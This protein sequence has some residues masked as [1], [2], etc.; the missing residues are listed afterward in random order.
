MG[1]ID[2]V[3]LAVSLAI[4]KYEANDVPLPLLF[5]EYKDRG[6][7]HPETIGSI[8][9]KYCGSFNDENLLPEEFRSILIKE[10]ERL[11]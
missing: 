11:L 4:E 9:K 3:N 2:E 1:S 5:R 10:M 6:L 7:Y 8:N